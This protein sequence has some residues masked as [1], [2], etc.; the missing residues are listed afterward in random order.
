MNIKDVE[1]RVDRSA[2]LSRKLSDWIP[3]LASQ[4][5]VYRM[6]SQYIAK[7]FNGI[8][9]ILCSKDDA[10]E[11]AQEN[12]DA[13]LKLKYFPNATDEEYD[14]IKDIKKYFLDEIATSLIDV[15]L[16]DDEDSGAMVMN[17]LPDSTIAFSNGV[18]DF[19]NDRWLFQYDK[20][21][22]E[23]RV[24]GKSANKEIIWYDPS[25]YIGWNFKRNFTPKG[26]SID[27]EGNLSVVDDESEYRISPLTL[28]FEEYIDLLK[29]LDRKHK[30]LFFELFYNMA[31]DENHCFS[32]KKAK[33]LAEI[34]GFMTMRSFSEFFV[35]LIGDGGNGKDT[36]FDGFFKGR[37]EP[38]VST[39]SLTDIEEDKFVVA[40]IAKSPMNIRS[41]CEQGTIRKSEM[42][43]QLTGTDFQT[44]E[45]KGV[46]KYSGYINCK[47]I[48]SANNKEQLKFNDASAGFMRRINMYELFYQYDS[49][50]DFMKKGDYY[51]TTYQ[52][53]MEFRERDSDCLWSFYYMCMFGIKVGTKNYTRPF[54]FKDENGVKLNDYN[55]SY[56]DIDTSV[57]EAMKKMNFTKIDIYNRSN[58]DT[59]FIL[60][61]CGK[62]LYKEKDFTYCYS[63]ATKENAIDLLLKDKESTYSNEH[64]VFVSVASILKMTGL[65]IT[66][67]LFTSNLKKI[68]K[69]CIMRKCTDNKNY[70]LC[71]LAYRDF[72]VMNNKAYKDNFTIR[73]DAK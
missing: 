44:V 48:F 41:E 70:I 66:P 63:D 27:D 31:H 5:C 18:Y 25:W 19:R 34:L 69:N 29:Q 11:I 21:V 68:Y 15:T 30:N 64:E 1:K 36:L 40:S 13:L 45:E 55:S 65:T 10:K 49:D 53:A 59:S 57:E 24:N 51:D 35:F 54:A 16:N 28:S 17:K 39:N 73:G 26:L 67:N 71:S 33:H 52:S 22:D 38:P 32:M 61:D 7:R 60:S 4:I 2:N 42:L 9:Y 72:K 8:S 14:R 20:Y 46:N 6:N 12:V 37:I 50:K 56:V 62:M 47:F 58:D 3:M 43:K 23:Y